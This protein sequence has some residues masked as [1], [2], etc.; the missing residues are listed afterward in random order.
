MQDINEL[1]QALRQSSQDKSHLIGLDEKY[2][3]AKKLRD[4]KTAKSNS[5][6]YTS[7]L[8]ILAD[9]TR[10]YSG[11]NKMRE[12]AP[13]RD[14]ARTSI[15]QN[16]NALGLYQ[17]RTAQDAA[18]QKQANYDKTFGYN[19][20]EAKTVR[21]LARAR[22]DKLDKEAIEKER[23]RVAEKLD[24]ENTRIGENKTKEGVRVAENEADMDLVT[25]IDPDTGKERTVRYNSATGEAFLDGKKILNFSEWPSAAAKTQDMPNLGSGMKT[26]DA[27]A[28]KAVEMLD[29]VSRVQTMAGAL[30]ASEIAEMSSLGNQL[31]ELGIDLLGPDI[32]LPLLKDRLSKYSDPVK[33]FMT[34]IASL[35]DVERNELFGSALTATEAKLSKA[36][37]PSISGVPLDVIEMRLD[38]MYG[39][40]Y[41]K[42]Q[43]ADKFVLEGGRTFSSIVDK[44]TVGHKRWAE[45]QGMGGIR[46]TEGALSAEFSQFDGMTTAEAMKKFADNPD[47]LD[48]YIRFKNQSLGIK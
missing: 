37:S 22:Q 45:S 2:A 36:S 38:R 10:Q 9:V 15:A 31:T 29:Q 4:T 33:Q 18:N 7:P 40:N 27:S 23:V 12:L 8:A 42:I 35:G 39:Q 20:D 3:D 48:N 21:G 5:V 43:S 11:I 24:T 13:Q 16:E 41:A 17:A 1:A 14:A 30:N 25:K 46:R 19:A 47:E 26:V 6:G 34:N 28:V 44:S 32:A